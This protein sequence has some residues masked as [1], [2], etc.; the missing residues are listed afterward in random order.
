MARVFE[1]APLALKTT[2]TPK[3]GPG[4]GVV[5]DLT[6]DACVICLAHASR[7]P[8]GASQKIIRFDNIIYYYLVIFNIIFDII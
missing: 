6:P 4:P 5:R 1:D 2:T 8:F 3:N 7:P